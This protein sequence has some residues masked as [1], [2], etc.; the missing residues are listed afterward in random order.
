MSM[1]RFKFEERD[2]D[3]NEKVNIVG[4]PFYNKP[5]EYSYA[6]YSYYMCFKC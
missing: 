6:I 5:K 3:K 4:D 2:K 1:E